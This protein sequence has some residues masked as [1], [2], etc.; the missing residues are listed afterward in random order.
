MIIEVPEPHINQEPILDSEARFVVLMCGR[1]F[2]KSE[3]SQ[4]KLITKAIQGEQIAYITP[5][6]KLAKQFY[7]KLSASLPYQSKDLKIYF[8]NGGMVEFFTGERLDNLRGRKFHGVIVDEASFISDLEDGWLNSIRPTLTD[9]KGWALFLSTPRGKNF[10]Y[11]LFMKG[12]EPN[13]E[14]YKFTTFDNPYIDKDEVEE[15]RR[16]LPAPVFEQ[17]YMANPMENAANP[18]GSQNIRDCIR[19]MTSEPVCFGIDLAKSYDWSVIIGLD[20]GGNVAYFDRFQK[21]WHSTKQVIK[22]LPRKPILL[23]STGVGDPIFEELQREGLMVEGLKFTQNSKQ[24]LMVGLQNAIHQKAISYPSGVIV[25]ELE[26][27]EYQ[28]TASGVKYSA[29]SGFNDDAV[30]SL[31]L[32]WSMYSSRIGRGT[33]S[34]L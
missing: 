1:R 20:A 7:E 26:I 4:I 11:S 5:T 33:Y 25:D 30:V 9:Y 19:P 21:D 10:F 6:Y 12:G 2:G 8:P 28:F 15:A 17:E 31:A 14:S 29:P 16:Q 3:L 18:F 23:D 22:S 27:F 34:F 32:A 13:W 24:Q